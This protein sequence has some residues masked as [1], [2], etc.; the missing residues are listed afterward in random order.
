MMGKKAEKACNSLMGVLRK[1]Y[2]FF[3]L[4]QNETVF[5]KQDDYGIF[6][7]MFQPPSR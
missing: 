7:F 2:G 1:H 3:K 4:C 5:N 6:I